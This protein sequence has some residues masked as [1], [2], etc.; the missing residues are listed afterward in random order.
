MAK[1]IQ[2]DEPERLQRF[3]NNRT[4]YSE[5]FKC[6]TLNLL[7]SGKS[8]D[9]VIELTGISHPTLTKWLAQWN[10]KKSKA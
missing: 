7:H 3:M 1:N 5:D 9:E 10:K 2:V 4:S 6:L 8:Q